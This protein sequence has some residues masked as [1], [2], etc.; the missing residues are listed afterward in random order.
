MMMILIPVTLLSAATAAAPAITPTLLSGGPVVG[1][2]Q[3]V[4]GPGAQMTHS[5]STATDISTY[6]IIM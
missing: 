6:A 2:G 1:P 4:V 5:S 3:P